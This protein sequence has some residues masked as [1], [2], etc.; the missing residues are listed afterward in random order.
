MLR[1]SIVD[2]PGECLL[3]LEGKLMSVW[4]EELR[5]AWR[6]TRADLGNRSIKVDV[7]EL[8]FVSSNGERLLLEMICNGALFQGGGV[9]VRHLIQELESQRENVRHAYSAQ[10]D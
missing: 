6:G 4:V 8:S 1:I 3:I 9:Y 2:T 7:S 5:N 10:A